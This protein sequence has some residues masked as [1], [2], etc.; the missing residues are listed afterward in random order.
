VPIL[1]A[2][3]L[4]AELIHWATLPRTRV[5]TDKHT[6]KKIWDRDRA[7][8]LLIGSLDSRTFNWA[9]IAARRQLLVNLRDSFAQQCN[10]NLGILLEYQSQPGAIM[11]AKPAGQ[12]A[13]EKRKILLLVLVW[14]VQ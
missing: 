11:V 8:V 13:S 10:S 6:E 5:T 3:A 2:K 9:S 7:L 4:K 14:R 12:D 1:V